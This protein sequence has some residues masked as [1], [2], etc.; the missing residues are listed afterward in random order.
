M[1]SEPVKDGGSKKPNRNTPFYPSRERTP[2]MS[3]PAH[4]APNQASTNGS[5]PATSPVHGP[6]GQW[7]ENH[8]GELGRHL[9]GAI[10]EGIQVAADEA[11]AGLGSDLRVRFPD[12]LVA[13]HILGG[14]VTVTH[15]TDKPLQVELTIAPI[16][17]EVQQ[18]ADGQSQRA[19]IITLLVF[20]GTWVVGLFVGLVA[21]QATWQNALV[22][23][24][25]VAVIIALIA[26]ITQSGEQHHQ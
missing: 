12:E 21:I 9:L 7:V 1:V 25:V 8:T 24:G 3:V 22:F 4:S 26:L 10:Q 2:T 13:D 18:V 23:S 20:L 16:T 17:V 5:A 19:L 14:N 11:A 6:D 15:V